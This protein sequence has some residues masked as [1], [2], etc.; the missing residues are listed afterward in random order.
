MAMI[1]RYGLEFIGDTQS[2]PLDPKT[3]SP[4]IGSEVSEF[5]SKKAS[6]GGYVLN[7]FSTES[8]IPASVVTGRVILSIEK[9]A[10]V[11]TKQGFLRDKSTGVVLYKGEFVSGYRHGMGIAPIF[12]Y[13]KEFVG[14]YKGQ[15]NYSL[16][17]GYGELT[18]ADG[19]VYKG[20]W[21]Y[22][23]KCG[24]GVETDLL[25]SKYVGLFSRGLRHGTG[26]YYW[27]DGCVDKRE[28]RYGKAVSSVPMDKSVKWADITAVEE[29]LEKTKQSLKFD[30]KFGSA[31][32]TEGGNA[33]GPESLSA[34]VQEKVPDPK[35]LTGLSGKRAMTSAQNDIYPKVKEQLNAAIGKEIPFEINWDSF[36][37][38][39]RATISV[40]LLTAY[41]GGF[42]LGAVAKTFSLICA[43]SLAKESIQEI[44]QKIVLVNKPKMRELNV[45]LT[46]GVLEIAGSFDSGEDARIQPADLKKRIEKV[47]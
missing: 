19:S 18:A 45:T 1:H 7:P 27:G 4:I 20:E 31:A 38:G 29:K 25:G 17:H 41:G 40:W 13:D 23:D 42:T 15:W 46:S 26:C 34:A 21:K 43:D 5:K 22:D 24:F 47:L 8:I 16:R 44:I 11:A 6:Q 37:E 30:E 36:A 32:T 2:L 12:G 3:R 39:N 33:A 9:E 35:P 10:S 14:D 28:Y